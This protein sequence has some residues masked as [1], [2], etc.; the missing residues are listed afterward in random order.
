MM[1]LHALIIGGAVGL[2]LAVLGVP[3]VAVQVAVGV[4]FGYA[5]LLLIGR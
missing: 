1:L 4:M 5:L 2:C 3:I